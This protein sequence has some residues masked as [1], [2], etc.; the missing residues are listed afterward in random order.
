[1]CFGEEDVTPELSFAST[2]PLLSH[3][4]R[5][6]IAF[7]TSAVSV[8]L[9]ATLVGADRGRGAGWKR[10]EVYSEFGLNFPLTV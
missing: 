6:C 5:Y 3:A 10:G 8:V 4:L 2:R 7:S 1:M 9:D